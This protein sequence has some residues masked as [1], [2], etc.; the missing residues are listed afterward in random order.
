LLLFL[1]DHQGSIKR[2]K[3][4]RK[5]KAWGRKSANAGGRNERAAQGQGAGGALMQG[6][7]R[8]KGQE[9][10]EKEFIKK[11]KTYMGSLSQ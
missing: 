4:K 10:C 6:A 7:N 1:S 3:K 5:K 2:K 11:K 9:G 8:K